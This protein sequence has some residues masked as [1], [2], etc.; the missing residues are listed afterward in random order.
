MTNKEACNVLLTLDN[1]VNIS[2]GWEDSAKNA[3][4]EAVKIAIKALKEKPQG[5]WIDYSNT[6]YKCPD[7]GYL[8]DKYCPNCQTKIIL[9]NCQ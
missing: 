8:L 1:L 2:E 9:P 7:C 4:S 6:F 5:E 3:V